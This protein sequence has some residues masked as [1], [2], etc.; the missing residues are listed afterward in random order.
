MCTPSAPP[1]PD[2][3]GIAASSDAAAKMAS[4]SAANDLAF[5]QGVYN[6]QKPYQQQLSDLAKQVAEQQL[7]ASN[8]QEAV[9]DENNDYWKKTYQPVERQTVMDAM[10]SRYLSAADRQSLSDIV[11]GTSTLTGKDLTT[12]MDRL[13]RAAGEGSAQQADTRAQ[14]QTNSAFQQQSQN[15]TRMGGNPARLAAAAASLA[16]NQSLARIGA[17]N[18]ARD[19]AMNTATGLRTGVANFGRNMPN[20]ALQSGALANQS[21]NSAVTNS[22]TG[23]LSNLPYAQYVSGATPNS[24]GAAQ[25]GVQGALGVGGLMNQGYNTNMNYLGQT[26]GGGMGALTG[27]IG[28]GASLYGSGAIGALAAVSDR[29]LKKDVEK[30]GEDSRGFNWYEF[31]Y[32]WGGGRRRGVMA[33]E[34]EKVIPEAVITLP[35]GGYKLVN[36]GLVG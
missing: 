23:Y 16:Q 22:N 15:L 2:Y 30:I 27:L 5:R 20:T 14:A 21:G 1:P 9:A 8:K 32:V 26:A 36:Y 4:D 28:A 17:Q 6:D 18:S 29:R 12:E 25:V 11:S 31:E 7:G 19:S 33:D 13:A 35:G 34:V 3:S 10:G 24:I